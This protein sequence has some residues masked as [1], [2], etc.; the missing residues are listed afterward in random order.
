MEEQESRQQQSSASE[1]KREAVDWAKALIV[2]GVLVV[3]IR[4]FLF[5]PYIV[6]G[7]SMQPNFHTGERIIVNKILYD[8]RKPQRGEVLVFHSG[9]DADYIKRVVA[10]P[11][12]T[13]EVRGDTVLVN[14]EPLPE[15]YIREPVDTA[16]ASGGTYNNKDFSAQTVPEGH[17]FVMGDN[18]PNSHDSR[19]IG[20]VPYEEIVGRA[21]VVIWPIGDIR[22][23]GHH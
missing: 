5:S 19:D 8:I 21:D 22:L 13:V 15:P 20:F 16:A 17:V 10:L 2:A 14:G 11:G 6:D 7:P 23:I 9:Y 1:W 4:W 12:E 3:V 18:R